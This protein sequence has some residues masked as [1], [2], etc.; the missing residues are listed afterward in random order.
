PEDAEGLGRNGED[1]TDLSG[2]FGGAS[3]AARNGIDP[4][5]PLIVAGLLLLA[6]LF[7][8][9]RFQW[10]FRGLGTVDAA[11]GKTRLLGSYGGHAAR[12]S[13]TTYE[14][15]ET[16]GRA[17]PEA[18]GPLRT[19]AEARVQERYTALGA[20]DA[21]RASAAQAWRRVARSLIGL[22]PA[23]VVRSL[24]RFVH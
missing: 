11:W 8:I 4:R 5:P 3:A 10:R 17:V 6:L 9:A 12:A 22:I 21:D 18:R 19:I 2:D 20:S 7:W 15:A 23:R 14:Y 24:S 13:Q 1:P 16:L